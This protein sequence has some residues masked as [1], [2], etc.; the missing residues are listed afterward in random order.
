MD[1]V[2]A[3]LVQPEQ[4]PSLLPPAGPGRM[5]HRQVDFV[6][7]DRKLG[8]GANEPQSRHRFEQEMTEMV[9][10][11]PPVD[12]RT[13][14]AMCLEVARTGGAPWVGRD[15]GA[16]AVE[17]TEAVAGAAKWIAS[18]G[19]Q[20]DVVEG[21]DARIRRF[22]HAGRQCF[23]IGRPIAPRLAIL[24]GSCQFGLDLMGL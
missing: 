24:G 15:V 2:V 16:V 19:Q 23:P 12:E 17:C 1:D 20:G 3:V 4:T 14:V 10:H 13:R 7:Q 5:R 8:M 18:A 9:H 6:P 22:R 21:L 11:N